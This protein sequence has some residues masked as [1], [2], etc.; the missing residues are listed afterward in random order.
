MSEEVTWS[1][2]QEKKH[3][4]IMDFKQKAQKKES[5]FVTNHTNL[6]QNT[7]LHF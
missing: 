5:I 7:T 1:G 4:K 2:D 3:T 6:W